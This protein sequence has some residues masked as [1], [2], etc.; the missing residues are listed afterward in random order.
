MNFFPENQNWHLHLGLP[1]PW[2]RFREWQFRNV[3]LKSFVTDFITR[4][5]VLQKNWYNVIHFMSYCENLPLIMLFW[6]IALTYMTIRN[7]FKWLLRLNQWPSKSL[8]HSLNLSY[9]KTSWLRIKRF[10]NFL[11]ISSSA[12]NSS[13]SFR[14]YA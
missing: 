6:T 8:H 5:T 9:F 7:Y 12:Q 3:A 1:V 13:N 4:R 11:F 10:S 2:I 14:R